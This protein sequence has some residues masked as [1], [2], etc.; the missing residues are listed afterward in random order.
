[1]LLLL[2][3]NEVKWKRRGCAFKGIAPQP[4]EQ[5][6][7]FTAPLGL[8]NPMTRMHVRLLG[9]CFKTGRRGHR[10]TRDRYAVRAEAL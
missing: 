3:L 1:M 6:F 7:A 4:A 10:P 9:P 2:P 5:T 8:V